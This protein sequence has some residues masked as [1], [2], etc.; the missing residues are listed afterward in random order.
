MS[1]IPTPA[2]DQPRE[3]KLWNPRRFG[4]SIQVR[5]RIRAF[6]GHG[7]GVRAQQG[8]DRNSLNQWYEYE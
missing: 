7:L 8:M 3:A 5:I 2:T 6:S 1:V 4:V